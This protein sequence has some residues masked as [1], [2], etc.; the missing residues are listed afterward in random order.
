MKRF[1]C[2]LLM[3]STLL[4]LPA[5]AVEHEL[6]PVIEALTSAW[7]A[8]YQEYETIDGYLEIKNIRIITTKDDIS[9]AGEYAV[10][11]FGEI[12]AVYEFILLDNIYNSAPFYFSSGYMNNVVLYKDGTI[13]AVVRS[14]F[15]DYHARTYAND[16]TGIIENIEDLGDEYNAVYNL[17][18]A[19]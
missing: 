4:T 10:T 13:E 16:F 8:D 12:A 6:D 3:L 5:H 17:L 9:S 14:P 2:I 11:Y 1:I 7:T 19:E 18:A 15:H